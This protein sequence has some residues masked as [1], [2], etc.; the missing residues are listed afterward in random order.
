[1]PP[2]SVWG[3]PMWRSMHFIALAYPNNPTFEDINNYKQYFQALGNVIPCQ[4]CREHYK[5]NLI[6]MPIDNYLKNADT[7][8]EWTVKLHN[9]VNKFGGKPQWT[10]EN[11][12]IHYLSSDNSN[13]TIID[14]VAISLIVAILII[15]L[16][17]LWII[18]K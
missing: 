7:L 15:I 1:M 8:F 6:N 10:V 16:I 5:K 17:W 11:A 9:T 4:I 14:K 2:P 13:I 18:K 3:G 12:K